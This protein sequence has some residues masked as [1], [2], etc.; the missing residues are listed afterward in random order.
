MMTIKKLFLLIDLILIALAVYLCVKGVYGFV[1]SK[2]DTLP[3]ETVARENT[4][5]D[6]PAEKPPFSDYRAI[7]QRNLFHTKTGNE[8]ETTEIP[9]DTLEETQLKLKLWGTISGDNENS[10]AIIED[11]TK[12]QQNVY[13]VNDTI[14]NATVMLIRPDQVV[15]SVSGKNESLELEKRTATST[16]SSRRTTSSTRTTTTAS[17]V[18]K[19]RISLSRAQVDSAMENLTDLMTQITI[20]PYSEEGV[21]GLS[22]SNIKPNSLFRR[23]GLRNGDVLVAVDGQALT[24]VDQAYKL[25]EDL[26]TSDTASVQINRRGRSTNIEYRIR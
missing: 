24:S 19:R 4:V 8:K 3:I 7:S 20:K 5:A 25:Y 11:E 10:Y 6:K 1:A 12:R 13:K 26:K 23:M 17:S 22:L 9:L 14:Q 21:D 15:L 2:L 18:S 16:T